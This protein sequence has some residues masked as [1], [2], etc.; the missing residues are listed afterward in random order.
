M[1]RGIG[2]N[3]NLSD[4]SPAVHNLLDADTSPH[5]LTLRHGRLDLP[6]RFG[7]HPAEPVRTYPQGR[8]CRELGCDALLSIY[9]ADIYCAQH[10]PRMA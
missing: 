6:D 1:T 7:G 9:N 2:T 5:Q 10:Q 4:R 8:V 3:G